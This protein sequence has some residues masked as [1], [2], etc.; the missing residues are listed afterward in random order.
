MIVI[1]NLYQSRRPI[2]FVKKF[3]KSIGA[4]R[5]YGIFGFKFSYLRKFTKM[6]SSNLEI[7]D[8]VTPIDYVFMERNNM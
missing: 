8:L 1:K 6:K 3:K 7:L 2:P 4:K 5:I